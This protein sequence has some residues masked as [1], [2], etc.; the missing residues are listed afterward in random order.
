[1]RIACEAL[2]RAAYEDADHTARGFQAIYANLTAR[3]SVR[4]NAPDA[5]A[6]P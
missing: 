5:D 2:R 1:L 4:T 6:R 3:R